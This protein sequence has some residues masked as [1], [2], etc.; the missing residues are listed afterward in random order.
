MEYFHLRFYTVDGYHRW[1]DGLI[2]LLRDDE[3][4]IPVT[5]GAY[6]L[7]TSGETMLTYP[8]G[9]SPIFYIGKADNLRSRTSDHKKYIIECRDDHSSRSFWPR[10]Q[11][12]A[13][14]GTSCAWYSRTGPQN[15]KNLEAD[16]VEKF[17]WAFG[18]IPIANSSWPKR[19]EPQ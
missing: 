4:T 15:P 13:A 16:L 5:G 17:Y 18:S 7:G 6:I 2:D 1:A 11:Y 12:G 10:Y 9:S 14:C 3:N 8:W 19:I